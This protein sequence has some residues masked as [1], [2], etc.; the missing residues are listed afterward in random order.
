VPPQSDAWDRIFQQHGRVFSEPHEDMAGIVRLLKDREASTVLD[1]GCGTGRHIV[2]L[3]RQGFRVYGLDVSPEAIQATRQWLAEEGLHASLALGS[4]T[5]PFP[6]ADGFFDAAISVQVVH[7][8]DIATIRRIVAE[9]TRVLKVGGFLFVT[10]PSQMN[11][12]QRFEEIEPNTFIPL[13]G[14][15]Q[16]LPHHYFT[17]EELREVFDRFDVVDIHLDGWVHYC[18][19]AFKR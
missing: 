14:P 9:L 17:P 2:Y 12:G 15:E 18:M 1:L 3:A 19:S 10:V 13:D 6:Y 7:H 5:E 8:A 4:M 16:G 11:Q